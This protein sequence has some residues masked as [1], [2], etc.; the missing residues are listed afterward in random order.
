MQVNGE[1]GEREREKKRCPVDDGF[2]S[3]FPAQDHSPCKMGAKVVVGTPVGRNV[4]KNWPHKVDRY[5]FTIIVGR[6]KLESRDGALRGDFAV[7]Q[8][9][10]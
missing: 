4:N 1:R 3:D 7:K 9:G 6:R 8:T 5:R 2:P 10:Q